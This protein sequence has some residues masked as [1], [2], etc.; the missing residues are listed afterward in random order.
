M[1]LHVAG[2][3][4]KLG[5]VGAVHKDIFIYLQCGQLEIPH[6]MADSR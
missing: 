2:N 5:L 6:S 4:R 3:D 1:N